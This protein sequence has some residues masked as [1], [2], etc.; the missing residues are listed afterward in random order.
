MNNNEN[1]ETIDLGDLNEKIKRADGKETTLLNDALELLNVVQCV[2][3]LMAPGAQT[4]DG[5]YLD[6]VN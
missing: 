4:E 3:N 2:F 1:P 5:K 6:G